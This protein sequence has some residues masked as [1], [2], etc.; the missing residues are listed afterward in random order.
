MP[1][2]SD[3][4]CAGHAVDPTDI[5][6]LC[7]DVDGV[8]TDGSILLDATGGELKR[9]H[10]RDGLAIKAWQRQGNRIAVITGRGCEALR[11]RMAEL[12]VEIVLEHVPDKASALASVQERLGIGPERT[13]F[14]GDDLADLPAFERS[15]YSMA[16]VDADPDVLK[17]A[18]WVGT[19]RGGD[20]AV[21]EAI[22]H[23][24]R[25]RGAWDDVVAGH[26]DAGNLA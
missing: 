14:M 23:L 20:A 17:R 15:G 7:L 22:E 4:S 5:E 19:R 26:L 12:G 1:D 9:F 21:R 16:P 11:H 24:L 18:S 10:V 8:M 13:A 3:S 2:H 6:L 25:A